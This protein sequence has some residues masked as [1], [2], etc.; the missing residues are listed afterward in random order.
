MSCCSAFLADKI[1]SILELST[2]AAGTT[3]VPVRIAGNKK[4]ALLAAGGCSWLLGSGKGY[5]YSRGHRPEFR[6]PS[7][8]SKVSFWTFSSVNRALNCSQRHRTAKISLRATTK[9][10]LPSVSI[11][12]QLFPAHS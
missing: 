7:T 11:F 2:S 3:A 8:G 1:A 12:N 4:L 5:M 9:Q 10:M 6:A